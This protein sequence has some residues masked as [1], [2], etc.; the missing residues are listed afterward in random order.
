MKPLIYV[1]ETKFH[2]PIKK[3]KGKISNKKPAKFIL[4]LKGKKFTLIEVLTRHR[5]IYYHLIELLEEKNKKP[6]LTIFGPFFWISF[7]KF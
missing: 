7:Q 6:M 1:D 4:I 2:L 3:S 5:M